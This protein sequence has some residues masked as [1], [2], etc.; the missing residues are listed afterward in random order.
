M[1][2]R[3]PLV[4]C[5][6]WAAL[7]QSGAPILL[8][9]P[10]PAP[11]FIVHGIDG[12]YAPATILG[13]GEGWS[14]ELAAPRETI[15]ARDWLGLQ[16][17]GRSRPAP[18][19]E[20][21]IL[22][23]TGD[24]LPINGGEPIWFDGERL[25][26]TPG[27]GLRARSGTKLSLFSPHVAMLLLAV[28][29]EVDDVEQFLARLQRQ[30]RDNDIVLLRDG[31]RIAGTVTRLTE[32]DGCEIEADGRK[33]TTPWP[34]LAGVAFAT[35]RLA[36]PR[37]RQTHALAVLASGARV[38]FASLR[39]DGRMWLGCTTTGVDVAIAEPDLVA[40]DLLLGQA[41]YLSD[42]TPV[43]YAHTPYLGIERPIG[44]DAATDGRPL[45]TGQTFHDKGLALHPRSRVTYRLDR[46]YRWFEAIVGLNAATGARG[47][48]RIAVEVDGKEYPLDDA[49]ERSCQQPPLPVHVDVRG[50]RELT[51][52]VDFGSLGDVQ[53]QVTWG[54]A[55]LVKG[56]TP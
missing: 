42:L 9:Q 33:V 27:G 24:R 12:P 53:A 55:R 15:A 25:R 45:R 3:I 23:G 18:L 37:P 8:A 44:A 34:K 1:S 49:C 14:V 39:F 5:L 2:R 7:T 13:L 11:R 40:L 54:G 41:A 38:H 32:L 21:F 47:R 26:F 31:D 28:P 22:L 29:N 30:N 36:R 19:T 50:A 51:L 4:L 16:Q 52:L 48:A 46:K 17:E 20:S 6:A 43:S 10:Q 56:E 35:T